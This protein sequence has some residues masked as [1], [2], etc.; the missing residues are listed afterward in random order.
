MSLAHHAAS[1]AVCTVF[2]WRIYW[3]I[4]MN[5]FCVE[6]KWSEGLQGLFSKTN[7][8]CKKLIGDIDYQRVCQDIPC[9]LS[10]YV[11]WML[12][13]R[14]RESTRER[15]RESRNRY[16]VNNTWVGT[17]VESH[18][19]ERADP[20]LQECSTVQREI[21]CMAL[22]SHTWGSF[23]K[24]RTSK[25]HFNWFSCTK[26]IGFWPAWWCQ[27]KKR[28]ERWAF[29]LPSWVHLWVRPTWECWMG[30]AIC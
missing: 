24:Q 26:L 1:I 18:K 8:T 5:G 15:E 6:N 25:N 2:C 7:H 17:K 23:F 9:T 13:T 4:S 12:D 28:W 11:A 21:N 29:P 14:E 16:L 30:Y 3:T 20:P 22:P 10:I 19:L 27:S